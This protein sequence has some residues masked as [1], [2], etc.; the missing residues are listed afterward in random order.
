[1]PSPFVRNFFSRSSRSCR[2][3]TQATRAA[4]KGARAWTGATVGLLGALLAGCVGNAPPPSTPLEPAQLGLDQSDDAAW[5]AADW[6]STFNDAQLTRLIELARADHPSIR[7]AEARVRE[8]QQYALA[9]RAVN[10]PDITLN[11]QV[12]REHFSENY[13]YPAPLGGSIATEGRVALDFSY[14]FDFW[15]RQRANLDAALRQ[16]DVE[17]AERSAAQL[18]LSI[19][20]AQNYFSLQRHYAD[21]TLIKQLVEQRQAAQQLVR[22]RVERGLASKAELEPPTAALADAEQELA[23]A[24]QRID[25]DLHQIAA[26]CGPHSTTLPTIAPV[27]MIDLP[28]SIPITL[29]A[30]LLARRAD[31][32]AQRLRAEVAG[33]DIVAAKAEFYPN[34]DLTAFFGVQ[35]IGTSDLFKGSSRTWGVG[36]ALH[37]PIFNRASLRAQLGARYAEY[38][39]AVAQYN[40][41]VLDAVRETADAG[42]AARSVRGQRAAADTALAALE[43]ARG[44]AATRYRQ[45]LSNQLELLNATI[46]TLNQQRAVLAV[47]DDQLQVQL[48]LIKALGGGYNDHDQPRALSETK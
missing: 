2:S 12:T 24:K 1:M 17:S 19:A 36:P 15:G 11:G 48:A 20:V 28:P 43:R 31:I 41:S 34:I 3:R 25:L 23:A 46:A 45:G 7:L 33:R 42:S 22:L 21:R 6:W 35:S 38:D 39:I 29:P 5:P 14:E 16:V 40:Q 44:A 8:A 27:T 32:A 10:Q 37:L 30:D 18:V 13:I 47:R 4:E 9:T 26:L